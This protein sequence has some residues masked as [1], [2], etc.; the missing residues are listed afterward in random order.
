MTPRKLNVLVYT[1]TGTTSESVRHC[2]LSLRQLLTPSY[3]IIP[4]NETVLLREPWAQTCALLVIPGGADLG[5][6]RALNGAGNRLIVDYV[7]RGGS[8][9]GFCAGGYYGSRRCEF[10][11]GD[12]SL[13]VI[14][15]RELG[16]FPGTCRGSAYGGFDYYSEKGARAVKLKLARGLLDDDFTHEETTSYFNG[17]GLFVDAESFGA[18]KV[19]V[20]ASYADEV[21]V[22]GGD[23]AVVLCHLGSGKALLTGPHPEFAAAQ[24]SPHPDV[25]H[26]ADLIAQLAAVDDSRLAFLRACLSKLGLEPSRTAQALPALTS[27]HLTSGNGGKLSRL[28]RSWDPIIERDG[29]SEELIRGEA[30]TFRIQS[31]EAQVSMD[32]LRRSLPLADGVLDGS[33]VVDYALVVKTIVAHEKGLP[34]PE[35]TP[36]FNHELYYSSLESYQAREPGVSSW[37]DV[38][39]YGDTVTSTNT[40]L[41]TNP[42]LLSTLPTGV[43]L[44]ASTQVSGRGRGT[45]V[46]IAPPGA[47]IFSTVIDHSAS[48]AISRPIVFLQYIAA[49]AIVEGIRSYADGYERLPVKIKWPN[50]IY[51]LNPDNPSSGQYVKVG[52]ILSQ[53]IYT[54]GAYKVV[55]GV[56]INATN[57]RPTTSLSDLLPPGA[58]SAF[59]VEAL[60]A[61]ILTRLETVHAQFVREGF[62]VNL[63]NRYYRHWLHTDQLITLETESGARARVRGITRDWGMLRVE[64][65]DG[66]GR[67]VGRLWTLQSDENS[68]DYWKGLVRRKV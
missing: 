54:D 24:L 19:E 22:Q 10:A 35:Q 11:V 47:L 4:I 13:E 38:L 56:G 5:Y 66:H 25:P 53:C 20:L 59:R 7:R 31:G 43:T 14:G 32:E 9:L 28:L 17:G 62:S 55:L 68:F 12:S 61:C 21:E 64:E 26:Y 16:F 51:A 48:L 2:I 36:L 67:G 8:Y 52:G 30:D 29:D 6:G 60:L 39:L 3:A 65:I 37:G 15:S 46:W 58:A 27:M 33:G 63:E 41:V 23:A 57:P 34:S 44:A 42:K 18:K 40:I 50:D 1:G 49:I 45:N